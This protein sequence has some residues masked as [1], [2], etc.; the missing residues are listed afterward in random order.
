MPVHSFSQN[1]SVRGGGGAVVGST[2]SKIKNMMC[3]KVK[4]DSNFCFAHKISHR[5]PRL[6]TPATTI[7]TKHT[8]C[9]ARPLTH[10]TCP[11][12]ASDPAVLTSATTAAL[13]GRA[14]SLF[15]EATMTSLDGIKYD[16]TLGHFICCCISA[17]ATIVDV[18][19]VAQ[20]LPL[21]SWHRC[22][23]NAELLLAYIP[24]PSQLVFLQRIYISIFYI[25][26][27]ISTLHT[28]RH[29]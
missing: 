17:C 11:L 20:Q 18:C 4:N 2:A 27:Y 26:N 14:Q 3:H 5:Q 8:S 19:D 22:T 23:C 24:T 10:V 28:T 13:P 15:Q 21:P 29:A 7:H 9:L 25:Y 12:L 16:H 6:H 1:I